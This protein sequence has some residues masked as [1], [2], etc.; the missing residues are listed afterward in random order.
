[1]NSFAII[2]RRNIVAAA[3]ILAMTVPGNSVVGNSL[4]STSPDG[5]VSYTST[6]IPVTESPQRLSL[7]AERWT[8]EANPFGAKGSVSVP[9]S[10]AEKAAT[11]WFRH[12][13]MGGSSDGTLLRGYEYYSNGLG[14]STIYWQYS[15]DTAST[16]SQCCAFDLYGGS[17]PSID[18]WG[19]GRTFVGTYVPPTSFYSGAGVLLFEFVDALDPDTWSGWWGDYSLAGWHDMRMCDIAADNHQQSW[20]WG[21][22][23]LV[24]NYTDADTSI[25]DAP[26]IFSQ[27]SQAGLMQLSWYPN[28]PDC[29]TTAADIDPATSKTYAV[30]DRWNAPDSQWQ[31]FV[32]Q[33][34]QNDWDLPTNAAVLR[35]ESTTQ[36]IR[37]PAIAANSGTVVIVAEVYSGTDSLTTDILCWNTS[38]GDVD[39]LHYISAVAASADRESR[40]RLAHLADNKFVCTFLKNDRLWTA[41]TCD[42]GASWSEVSPVSEIGEVVPD[43]YRVNDISDAGKMTIWQY[44]AGSDTLLHVAALGCLDTDA[45]NVCDCEDNCPTVANSDQVDT[46]GDG[47]GDL[48]DICP[49]YDDHIDAD[50]DGVPDGC[51]NCPAV[52]NPTQADADG[53]GLGDACDLC[54]DID[55]D[56]FG[57][58]GYSANTCPQDNCP[59]TANPDQADSDTDGVGDACD[60]CLTT[61]NP[62]QADADNDGQGDLCDLC[63]DT[64]NDGY[65]DPMFPLNTCPPDNCPPIFNPTQADS[66]GDGIGDACDFLC[67]DANGD[68]K[69]NIGDAV[70]LVSY[71]FRSGPI[72][73]PL[74]AG[75]ANCDGKVNIGDAVYLV[76]YIFRGGPPPC[77]P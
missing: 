14:P 54:T 51:D 55:G 7:R 39:S 35:F 76:S 36:Q 22:I 48:C 59:A 2:S 73:A 29:R 62:D 26:H 32:R 31:L 15:Q 70:Y 74:G 65:G 63:T 12:P 25:A 52:A 13:A 1:M 66:N 38:S 17:Y 24:M 67:G 3:L 27:M 64:D 6:V 4:A 11:E 10:P 8:R 28:F 16:W 20:N 41:V 44:G 56:G 34:F 47:V 53:D 50:L 9:G 40:P 30:Y 46:D 21:L 61:A 23:S 49:G 60:N 42:G 75:D 37:Y 18:Y 71:I 19:G 33:D 77:C 69:I 68:G 45:D 5:G 72:P 57:N 58:P 43:G